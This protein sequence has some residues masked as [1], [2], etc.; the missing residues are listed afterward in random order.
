[1]YQQIKSPPSELLVLP[2]FYTGNFCFSLF[3][4]SSLSAKIASCSRKH[5]VVLLG[6]KQVLIVSSQ[7]FGSSI[8][9]HFFF[10]CHMPNSWRNSTQG[11]MGWLIGFRFC[12]TC[13]TDMREE[14]REEGKN[15][16]RLLC[17]V[18]IQSGL[19]VKLPSGGVQQ[20]LCVRKTFGPLYT[21]DVNFD[22]SL[23]ILMLYW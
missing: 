14:G 5:T 10:P 17:I 18:W 21:S 7:Q 15:N 23:E 6:G 9:A 2:N 12:L 13:V 8:L 1:M 19:H 16:P 22:L 3:S 11:R 4:V 20:W